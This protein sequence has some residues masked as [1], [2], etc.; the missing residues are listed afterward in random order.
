MGNVFGTFNKDRTVPGE[1]G[2]FQY[3]YNM[4]EIVSNNL[5]EGLSIQLSQQKHCQAAGKIDN[6]EIN[7][8]TD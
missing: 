4:T 7:C 2:H 1:Y 8:H 6:Q 5:L 3:G